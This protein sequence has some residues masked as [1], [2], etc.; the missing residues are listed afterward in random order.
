MISA[1]GK[2][3]TENFQSEKVVFKNEVDESDQQ[4]FEF[5]K[6]NQVKESINLAEKQTVRDEARA[7]YGNLKEKKIKKIILLY[8]DNSFEEFN[9]K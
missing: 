4:S 2:K 1:K 6:S 7:Y 8:Q 9:P 3:D 5:D